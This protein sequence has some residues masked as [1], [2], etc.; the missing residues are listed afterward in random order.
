MVQ[1]QKPGPWAT[2]LGH[3]LVGVGTAALAGIV[4]KGLGVKSVLGR[5][6]PLL[7]GAIGVAA[8]KAFDAPV[9]QVLAN[10]FG[11]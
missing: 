1:G 7:V 5:A 9:S 10:Q 4:I 8:H 11:I 2:A 3:V 6:A